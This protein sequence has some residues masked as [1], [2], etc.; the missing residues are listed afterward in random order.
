MHDLE[1]LQYFAKLLKLK[2]RKLWELIPALE[3]L[4]G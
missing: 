4:Q 3:T 2:V 1:L